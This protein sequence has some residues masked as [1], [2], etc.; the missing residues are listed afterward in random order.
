MVF[1][2]APQRALH[3]DNLMSIISLFS[4]H[5]MD[6]AL[7]KCHAQAKKLPNKHANLFWFWPEMLYAVH[8]RKYEITK[9]SRHAHFTWITFVIILGIL[10]KAEFSAPITPVFIV[11]WSLRNHTDML[12]WCLKKQT[13]LNMISAAVV[14]INIFVDTVIFFI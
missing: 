11:T 13:F 8:K 4:G 14:Q 3:N 5:H 2:Y 12:I 9:C 6:T 10:F 1:K 7:W